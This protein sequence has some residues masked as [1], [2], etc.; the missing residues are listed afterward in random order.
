VLENVSIILQPSEDSGLTEDFIIP[1]PSLT[2]ALSPG[3]VYVSFTRDSPDAFA[4]GSFVSSMKFVSKEVDPSTGEP[5]E[6]GFEDDYQL[7]EI[8]LA[9][10]DYIVPSY[11]SFQ[12]EWDKLTGASATETFSLSAMESIKGKHRATTDRMGSSHICSSCMRLHRR[13]PAH[14]AAGWIGE[15]LVDIVTHTATFWSGH[16]RCWQGAGTMQDDVCSWRGCQ[17]RVKRSGGEARGLRPYPDRDWRLNGLASCLVLVYTIHFFIHHVVT[18][19]LI[20]P[21]Y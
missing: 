6:E 7:E 15:P 19:N 8:E 1:I 21:P 9:A 14:G 3:I 17:S 10:A 12:T 11:A 4:Q 20:P 2:A 16:G 18:P 5:E 13:D